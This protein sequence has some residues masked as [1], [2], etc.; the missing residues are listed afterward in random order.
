L[1]ADVLYGLVLLNGT[2]QTGGIV[3]L[4]WI[5]FYVV[6]GAA[7]LEP[8]MVH[9]AEPVRRSPLV[10][11]RAR[12]ILLGSVSLMPPGVLLY[13]DLTGD[14][15]DILVNALASAAIFVLVTVRLSGLVHVA[16]QSAQR[17]S[18]LR[19]TGESLVS[20]SSREAIY[21]V[22]A[23]AMVA[24]THAPEQHRVLVAVDVDERPKLVYDSTASDPARSSPN[25]PLPELRELLARHG[26]QLREQHFALTDSDHVGSLIRE[27]L[28]PD[29]PVLLA[30]LVRSGTV[31]G[32]IAVCGDEVERTDIIDA[33]CAMAAQM[34]L[35]LE[36][37][38]LTDRCSSARTR[39]T[40]SRS[41]R[42]HQTSSWSSTRTSRSSMERRRSK[43]SS[44]A[45]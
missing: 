11:S 32:V 10:L 26:T 6:W 2:W 33:V 31:R 27:R 34:V 16:R 35:A 29:V 39:P 22:S 40:S 8:D 1:A 12:L 19:H 18:L 37:A 44:V 30:A 9:L 41:S 21:A 3:D 42:T 13:E 4:G 23:Q 7:A 24:M 15:H 20:A 5:I 38:G 28:G 17:E 25:V 14:P 36:S 43:P 45:S